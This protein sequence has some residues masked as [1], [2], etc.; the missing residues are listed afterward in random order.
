MHHFYNQSIVKMKNILVFLVF[1]LL[2]SC[3]NQNTET[4]A[5]DNVQTPKAI[6]AKA[7]VK[8]SLDEAKTFVGKKP[9]EIKLFDQLNLGQRLEKLLGNEF[10]D[11]KAD[12]ND[13]NFIAQ[14]GEILY[15]TGCRKGA[16]AD[17]KY[18][19]LLD[20]MENNINVINIRNGRPRSF[21]EGAVIGMTDK[22]AAEF[23]RVRNSAGL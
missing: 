19:I 20:I 9:T 4:K 7:S 6:E 5:M 8:K 22:V 12:W 15:F 17:N 13:D 1:F 18:F 3:K 16:C 11:F 10:S 2:V 21:E 23:E 14:D